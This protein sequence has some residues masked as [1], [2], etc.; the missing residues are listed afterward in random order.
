MQ[1][2]FSNDLL[3]PEKLQILEEADM[4]TLCQFLGM[5]KR[6][7]MKRNPLIDEIEKQIYKKWIIES[8]YQVDYIYKLDRGLSY[9]DVCTDD[10]NNV[11]F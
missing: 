9:E 6:Q 1:G 4:K 11:P 5:C 7:K 8:N 10:H 3:S 2:N